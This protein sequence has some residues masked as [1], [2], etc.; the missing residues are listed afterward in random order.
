MVD[1]IP[2][3]YKR[4]RVGGP[5]VFEISALFLI[6][7]IFFLDIFLYFNLYREK[8]R[9]ADKLE[10]ASARLEIVD[11]RLDALDFQK[12]VSFKVNWALIMEKLKEIIPQNLVIESFSVKEDNSFELKGYL[13]ESDEFLL[14]IDKI[15]S[16]EYFQKVIIEH[17]LESREAK[18]NLIEFK[19]RGE[20]IQVGR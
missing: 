18:M 8:Q 12:R 10:L 9:V 2:I 20:I 7:I 14:F 3:D 5:K 13:T 11:R 4:R 1:F 19:I 17:S 15:S 6:I 16:F